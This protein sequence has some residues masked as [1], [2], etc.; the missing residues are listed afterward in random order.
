MVLHVEAML[1]VTD[2]G[3]SK[4]L[5]PI[6]PPFSSFLVLARHENWDTESSLPTPEMKEQMFP[7]PIPRTNPPHYTPEMIIK[8]VWQPRNSCQVVGCSS[9][10]TLACSI[11][12]E[13]SADGFTVVDSSDGLS[14]YVGNVQYFQFGA[15]GPVL[16]LRY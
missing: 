4:P 8:C 9:S 14:E 5:L 16:V 3:S 7:L 12:R 6:T 10:R 2:H 1:A 15:R 11:V 13:Q